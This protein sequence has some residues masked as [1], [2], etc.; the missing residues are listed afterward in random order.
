MGLTSSRDVT[1]SRARYQPEPNPVQPIFLTI[2]PT[3]CRHARLPMGK[4]ALA[5][6]SAL[7]T[8][9][10]SVDDLGRASAELFQ[11]HP[12]Y[13]I[14]TSS[15]GLGDST[16]ARVLAEIGDDPSRF[17]DG[18]ALK[19]YAG[20]AL[21]TRASGRSISITHRRIKNDRLAAAGFNCRITCPSRVASVSGRAC[22]ASPGQVANYAARCGSAR[23]T[24]PGRRAPMRAARWRR[25]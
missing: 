8:A 9:C 17:I 12:H 22:G 7:D 18:R 5:L 16:G 11:S 21:I 10:A 24:T 2:D 3:G 15:P 1:V 23:T 13:A 20:S 25:P 6:L 14:S 4:Q 19:A